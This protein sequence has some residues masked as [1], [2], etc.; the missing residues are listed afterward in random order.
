MYT[1]LLLDVSGSMT[2]SGRINDLIDAAKLF[3]EKVG[4]S[5]R[6]AVYAFDG[7][8]QLHSV[9]PFTSR[10]SSVDGGLEGLRTWTP[11]DNSTNLH[12]GVVE[13]L[14]TLRKALDR[15]KKPL[16]FGT[17]VVF[18]D[19]AD[20]AA[21]V[22]RQEMLTEMRKEEYDHFEMFAIGLGDPGELE[23]AEL[24]DIGRDGTVIGTEPSK[25]SEAFEKVAARIDAHSKR[26]Y[27]LSYCTPARKGDHEVRIEIDREGEGGGSGSLEYKFNA[28]GFGPPPQCDPERKP[29]F[30]L[31]DVEPEDASQSSASK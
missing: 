21:R 25:I 24:E 18:S 14:K 19:G 10:Q 16:K 2:E 20:R 27:L 12:G 26:F 23:D 29:T 6:V 31:E 7:S 8:K 5:Q 11:K 4:Q 9:V 30:D 3:T 15:E 22:S 17:V 1:I 28:D 13:G